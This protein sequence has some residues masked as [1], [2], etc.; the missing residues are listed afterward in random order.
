LRTEGKVG[1]SLQAE[2]DLRAEGPDYESL[3]SLGEE[4][5]FLMITSAA[6]VARGA[7]AVEVKPSGNRKCDRCWQ[8]MPDV[9]DEALCGRCQSNLR[10]P[11]ESRRFV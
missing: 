11:G 6:R 4:L 1:A 10:G 5:R 2:V 9:S 3:A 7:P 8:Y